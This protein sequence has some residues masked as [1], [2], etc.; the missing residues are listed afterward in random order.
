MK[1]RVC[2]CNASI[3]LKKLLSI[4]RF[5]YTITVNMDRMIIA[6]HTHN[7][8]VCMWMYTCLCLLACVCAFVRTCILNRQTLMILHFLNMYIQ[9]LV[10]RYYRQILE[11]FFRNWKL[12]KLQSPFVNFSQFWFLFF[13]RRFWM[14]ITKIWIFIPL[15]SCVWSSPYKKFH[16]IKLK[17]AFIN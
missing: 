16:K 1:I 13:S 2:A 11:H 8:C 17:H 4:V 3:K 9:I 12:T 5:V 10:F 6:W 15:T 14:P 7:M